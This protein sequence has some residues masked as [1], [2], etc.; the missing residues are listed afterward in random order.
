LLDNIMDFCKNDFKGV[1]HAAAY[2][3]A[4]DKQ[5]PDPSLYQPVLDNIR[6]WDPNWVTLSV[7]WE[8]GAVFSAD[9]CV[10]NMRQLW[11]GCDWSVC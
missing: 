8:T 1:E 7:Q 9:D 2:K 4:K 10:S 3:F 6:K 5:A 11:D